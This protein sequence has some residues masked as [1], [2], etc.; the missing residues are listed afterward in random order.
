M[1]MRYCFVRMWLQ[2]PVSLQLQTP[3]PHKILQK[4]DGETLA[5]AGCVESTKACQTHRA[6]DFVDLE[7]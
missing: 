7:V 6:S 1:H 4:A 3:P 5:D 2:T